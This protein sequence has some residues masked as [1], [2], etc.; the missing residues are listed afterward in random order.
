M[1]LLDLSSPVRTFAPR[2]DPLSRSGTS[3]YVRTQEFPGHHGLNLN[4]SALFPVRNLTRDTLT[5]GHT[6]VISNLKM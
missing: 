6:Q 5:Q 2:S 3:I 4:V 1:V